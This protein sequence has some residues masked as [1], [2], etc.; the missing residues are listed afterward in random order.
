MGNYSQ[1]NFFIKHPKLYFS[2][3]K[4]IVLA[5]VIISWLPLNAQTIEEFTRQFKHTQQSGMYVLSGFATTNIAVSAIG[6]SSENA[7]NKA[8]H[9]MNIG[10]NG[11]NLV[12]GATGLIQ[13][14]RVKPFNND[15]KALH[16][17]ERVETI[18]LV[19]AV[20]DIA[21]ITGGAWLKETR[22]RNTSQWDNLTGWGN[23]VMY[24]GVFLLVFDGIMYSLHRYN[25]E[26]LWHKLQKV[27]LGYSP[28]GFKCIVKF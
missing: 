21:Y 5:F 10:W 12:L 7:T 17:G 9:Q 26:K 3:M 20:L 8:F 28:N 2:I 1:C 27:Q 14:N 23:A 15:V 24:N 13:L 4:Y 11:V 22:Y 19:N 25:N 16:A 6:V 18:F